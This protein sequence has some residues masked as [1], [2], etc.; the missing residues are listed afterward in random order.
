[1]AE[2]RRH[3]HTGWG[4]FPDLG[5]R[6][7]VA[8]AIVAGLALFAAGLTAGRG[9]ATVEYRQEPAARCVSFD[10]CPGVLFYEAVRTSPLTNADVP[11]AFVDSTSKAVE[12]GK[13]TGTVA[14][15]EFLRGMQVGSA[16]Q[17]FVTKDPRE[18]Y[19]VVSYDVY[20]W[21]RYAESAFR[22]D[23]GST[24]ASR[25]FDGRPAMVR[26]EAYPRAFCWRQTSPQPEARCTMVVRNAIARVDVSSETSSRRVVL[27]RAFALFDSA[28]DHLH[29]VRRDFVSN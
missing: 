10:G 5:E 24:L 19:G 13:M 26:N 6:R 11:A 16:T 21:A 4:R 15:V 17:V 25:Y 1:M 2:A 14:R 23:V 28:L 18:G 20:H 7:R 9:E 3:R 8:L 12:E 22:A 27:R 29:E